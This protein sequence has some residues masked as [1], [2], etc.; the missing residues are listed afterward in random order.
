ME[1]YKIEYNKLLKRY[2]NGIKYIQ[3]H[4]SELKWFGEIQKIM[5][6]L[7]EMIRKYNISGENV[8]KGF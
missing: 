1:E 4:P 5:N 6:D 3:T 8:L 7:D 2:E